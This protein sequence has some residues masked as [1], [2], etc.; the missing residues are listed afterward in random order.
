MFPL[1]LAVVLVFLILKPFDKKSNISL[2][3]FWAS[4][5]LGKSLL[6]TTLSGSLL[7][8]S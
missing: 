7:L 3:V 2:L 1:L 6:L 4:L 8:P 5:E